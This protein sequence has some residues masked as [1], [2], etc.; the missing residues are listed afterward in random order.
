MSF[1]EIDSAVLNGNRCSK[2]VRSPV[3]D[4]C[5]DR[6]VSR[7]AAWN[8]IGSGTGDSWYE[9]VSGKSPH[10]DFVSSVADSD[11]SNVRGSGFCR[12]NQQVQV[13]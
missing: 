4:S 12:F 13:C 7:D 6:G 1:E 3:A 5:D 8:S 2:S 10:T 11:Q 9:F